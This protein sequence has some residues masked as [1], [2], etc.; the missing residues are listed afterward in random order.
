ML[1]LNKTLPVR[2]VLLFLVSSF[3]ITAYSQIDITKYASKELFEVKPI[4]SQEQIEEDQVEEEEYSSQFDFDLKKGIDF[5][6]NGDYDDAAFQFEELL[7][8][9][10]EVTLLH[11]YL[12][13][14]NYERDRNEAAKDHFATT[15]RQSPLFLEAKYMLGILAV[16]DKEMSEART[17]LKPLIEVPK[18]AAYGHHGLG[19]VALYE[20]SVQRAYRNFKKS[21][22]ADSSFLEAYIPMINIDLFYNDIRRARK[23]VEKGLR[24]DKDWQQGIIIRGIISLLQD[25]NTFQFERD[26]DRLLEL[27]PSNYHYHSIKGF[28]EIELANYS[29]AI[30]LFRTAYNLEVDSARKGEFKFSSSLKRDEAIQ[31][32]LNYYDENY[33]M[34]QSARDFLEKGICDL[35]S[36]DKIEALEAFDQALTFED[37]AVINTF[38]G[39]T[40]KTMSG[41]NQLVIR[42]YTTA[43]EQDSTNWVAL[44][45]RAE[46]HRINEDPQAA[47]ND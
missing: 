7:S 40:Q 34:D 25:E 10:P 42:D 14:V 9:N 5:W 8:E 21:T 29:S 23:V 44:S 16:E 19:L 35:I 11:Y 4:I 30:K 24:A 28:L 18:Y 46:A 3:S 36:G 22:E 47:Y 38:K 32:S 20:G 26:I 6:S 41:R 37:N 39:T 45:Y 33:D 17:Y 15:L 1:N 13:W 2:V 12:G 31:R 43:I 27:D